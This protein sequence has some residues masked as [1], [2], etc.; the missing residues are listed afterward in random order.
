MDFTVYDENGTLSQ[1]GSSEE[2]THL[3]E[4]NKSTN[5]V[6]KNDGSHFQVNIL[7]H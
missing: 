6:I 5:V 2:Y 7:P 3:L 1:Y 4:V